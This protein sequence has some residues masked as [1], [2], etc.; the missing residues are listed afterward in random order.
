MKLKPLWPGWAPRRRN[1]HQ[2]L[3]R[4]QG[5]FSFVELML[6]LALIG[7]VSATSIW[8][9]TDTNRQAAA[10]RLFTEAQIVAQNQVELFQTDGPFNP[11]LSQVPLALQVDTRQKQG[12]AVYTDPHNDNI[13]VTGT[14]TTQVT[15]PGITLNSVN[16]NM[17]QLTVKITYSFAGHNYLVVMNSMRT[18]D[19]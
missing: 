2:N 4:Q 11:Q 17:R 15:D 5:G 7:G 8:S 12:M 14:L 18:S 6:A 9:L 1:A 19:L 16:L 3:V 10:N 13:V